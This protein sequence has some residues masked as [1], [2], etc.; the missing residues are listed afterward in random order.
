MKHETEDSMFHKIMRTSFETFCKNEKKNMNLRLLVLHT[1]TG[2][3]T[4]ILINEI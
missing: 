1:I 2:C 4:L 3:L